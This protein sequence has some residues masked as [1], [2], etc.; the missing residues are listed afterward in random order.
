[1]G[2]PLPR[3]TSLLWKATA[4]YPY[5]VM[6]SA[7]VDLHYG[8][9]TYSCSLLRFLALAIHRRFLIAYLASV[10]L[11]DGRGLS[12]CRQSSL[13]GT[14]IPVRRKGIRFI[15]DPERSRSYA[16]LPAGSR[17]HASSN[18]MWRYGGD[19]GVSYGVHQCHWSKWDGNLS[20]TP[21]DSCGHPIRCDWHTVSNRC[22]NA[23]RTR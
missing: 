13:H 18:W 11:F 1:M 9:S 21:V 6:L 2:T 10:L 23:N 20:C 15:G 3:V 14:F 19:G 22:R 17:I 7:F 16:W 8:N 12:G 5:A 4:E